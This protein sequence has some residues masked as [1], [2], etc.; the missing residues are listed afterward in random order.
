[1]LTQRGY[2]FGVSEEGVEI[3]RGK[4]QNGR[5]DARFFE[6]LRRG[7]AV[8]RVVRTRK[9]PPPLVSR[10]LFKKVAAGVLLDG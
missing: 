3:V 5:V 10:P 4:E 9:I 7:F 6:D 1:M 8:F 2:F